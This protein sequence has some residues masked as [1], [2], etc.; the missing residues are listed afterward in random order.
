[1]SIVSLHDRQVILD[2]LKHDPQRHVYH[3]GDLDDVQFNKTIC[4]LHTSR[5]SAHHCILQSSRSPFAAFILRPPRTRLSRRSQRFH[6]RVPWTH[7]RMALVDK[8][9]IA[10][11][12]TNDVV[13]LT[14]DNEAELAAFYN[15]HCPGNAFHRRMLETGSFFGVRVDGTLACA[16]G[17]HVMSPR[18]GVA[19]IGTVTTSQAYR[20]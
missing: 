17:L 13:E 6:H 8:D 2:L 1:M 12:D 16:A 20:N 14:M 5:N 7:Y 15:D 11:F 9:H 18:Y 10:Q 3:I 19:A 4:P